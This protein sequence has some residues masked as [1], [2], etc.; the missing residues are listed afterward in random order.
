MGGL[1]ECMGWGHWR[2]SEL[3]FA[4]GVARRFLLLNM[5]LDVGSI[6]M[7]TLPTQAGYT[8]QFWDGFYRG[9]YG[10]CIPTLYMK[11]YTFSETIDMP[12]CSATRMGTL[13]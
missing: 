1:C 9:I 13:F 7:G 11:A 6:V 2:C 3:V 4:V 5:W 8:C 12:S 10:F